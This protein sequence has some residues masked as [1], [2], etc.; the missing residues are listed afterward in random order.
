[1]QIELIILIPYILLIDYNSYF[2]DEFTNVV[3]GEGNI[4]LSVLNDCHCEQ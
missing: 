1:M 2:G 3:S 4:P